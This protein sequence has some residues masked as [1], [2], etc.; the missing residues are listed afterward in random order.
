[1]KYI[2]EKDDD[3]V[4]IKFFKHKGD[5]IRIFE[6]SNDCLGQVVVEGNSYEECN[7]K[8]KYVFDNIEYNVN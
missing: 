2:G 8:L 4:Q 7:K 1:M 3:I 6:D 5:K